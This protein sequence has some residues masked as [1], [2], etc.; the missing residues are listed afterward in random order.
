M[1]DH[2]FMF[3]LLGISLM[4]MMI[5]S[6]TKRNASTPPTHPQTRKLKESNVSRYEKLCFIGEFACGAIPWRM[7]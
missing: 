3:D 2:H 7:P 5:V 4:L 6:E 1:K